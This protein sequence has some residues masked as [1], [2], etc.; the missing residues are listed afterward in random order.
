MLRH[1]VAVT[2][3]ANAVTTNHRNNLRGVDRHD[4]RPA[5]RGRGIA[6]QRER[7]RLAGRES[8]SA[9]LHT[10]LGGVQAAL[11]GGGATTMPAAA[12]DIS[13]V[14]GPCAPA[15]RRSGRRTRLPLRLPGS[16]RDTV[17]SDVLRLRHQ[18]RGREHPDHCVH[19][20]DALGLGRQRPS[21]AAGLGQG[22]TNT[23]APSVTSVNG[24]FLMYYAVELPRPA[25]SASRSPRRAAPKARSSTPRRATGMP[26]V[27]RRL[28]RPLGVHRRQRR[29]VPGLEV[30]RSRLVEDLGRA[31][32]RGGDWIC[33]RRQPDHAARPRTRPGRRE[34][35][36]RRTSFWRTATTSCSSRATTG[37]AP[38]TP[39]AS[40]S[41]PG[42]SGRARTP[43]RTPILSSGYRARRSG[44]RVGLRDTSG[45]FWLAF[46]AWVP[47]AVGFPNSRDLYLR[48]LDLSGAV[49]SVAAPGPG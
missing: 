35:S 1:D 23:W 48:G 46:H 42:R 8:G 2:D 13:A 33:R 10:C 37:T 43:R 21:L 27:A 11:T 28:D 26:A 15:G 3:Y 29:P 45:D 44:W 31:A 19:G 24:T 9:T 34:R 36:R 20:P 47:G 12:K 49:P 16:R 32:E 14:S 22:R 17:R 18:L 7:R 30:R 38:T 4:A 40:R 39:S 25:R 41:A 6:Q 5:G